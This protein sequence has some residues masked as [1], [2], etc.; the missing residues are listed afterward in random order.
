MINEYHTHPWRGSA[1]T[2]APVAIAALALALARLDAI[3]ARAH[4]RV[5][6][7]ARTAVCECVRVRVC[8]E[9]G[10]WQAT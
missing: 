1:I 7:S 8:A 4:A 6:V 10:Q 5:C 3:G 9:C 2:D